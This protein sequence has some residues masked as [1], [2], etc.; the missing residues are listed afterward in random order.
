MWIVYI[1][2]HDVSKN[3]YIGFTSDLKRRLLQHNAKTTKSTKR[4]IGMWHIIYAEAYRSRS[5]AVEREKRLKS[6]GSAKFN[7]YK[8]IA[9]SLL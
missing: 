6:H 1:I 8:R 5:D 9:G 3:L 2:Q 4:K 7:L